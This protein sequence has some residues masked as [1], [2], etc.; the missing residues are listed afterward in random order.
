MR[1][2]H[3]SELE[4]HEETSLFVKYD[5]LVDEVVFK[6]SKEYNEDQIDYILIKEEFHKLLQDKD[7]VVDV[8]TGQ[9]YLPADMGVELY[10]A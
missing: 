4:K 1:Y 9:R 5:D 6:V 7:E 2:K 10:D 8:I 3:I